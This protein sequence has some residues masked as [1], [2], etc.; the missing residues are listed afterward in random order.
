M[1]SC[2]KFSELHELRSGI[3]YPQRPQRRGYHSFDLVETIIKI[4]PVQHSKLNPVQQQAQTD[5]NNF[6]ARTRYVFENDKRPDASVLFECFKLF[7]AFFFPTN[8]MKFMVTIAWI[9]NFI[10]SRH[11]SGQTHWEDREGVRWCQIFLD[12]RVDLLQA[13]LRY[14]TILNTLLHEACHWFLAEYSCLCHGNS[15]SRRC[16][17]TNESPS[18]CT[19]KEAYIGR[20]GHGKP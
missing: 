10:T 14:Q 11:T 1:T 12:P 16:G 13:N 9:D 4:L 20:T 6:V 19:C 7:T 15:H 2:Q 17:Y 8:T 3:C 18:G 5:Y